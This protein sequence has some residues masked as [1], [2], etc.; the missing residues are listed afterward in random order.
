[1]SIRSRRRR[2]CQRPKSKA[3]I[4]ASASAKAVTAASNNVAP[5]SAE[6][7]VGSPMCPSG[8]KSLDNQPNADLAAEAHVAVDGEL[9]GHVAGGRATCRPGRAR[10]AASATSRRCRRGSPCRAPRA[11]TRRPG[12]AARRDGRGTS[13]GRAPGGP[14]GW[15][16]ASSAE[17]PPWP[18][19][20]TSLRAGVVATQRPMSSSTRS[21]V[22]ALSQTCPTDQACSFDFV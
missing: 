10:G 12:R 20:N 13:A 2:S 14:R 8:P 9:L 17:L 22:S 4:S 3:A 19:K 7:S 16:L 6:A 11:P 5:R 18:L 1:M 21:I 15:P